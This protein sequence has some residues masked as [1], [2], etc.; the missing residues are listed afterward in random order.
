MSWLLDLAATRE[1]V[2]GGKVSQLAGGRFWPRNS[3]SSAV[4]S[5]VVY[6]SAVGFTAVKLLAV[7]GRY[8]RGGRVSFDCLDFARP[9]ALLLTLVDVGDGKH[10]REEGCGRRRCCAGH[11]G[12]RLRRWRGY[13]AEA[14][15]MRRESA[16]GGA[17][18]QS[19]VHAQVDT[20]GFRGGPWMQDK[21][22]N[23]L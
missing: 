17:M 12:R 18:K 9:G 14:S 3:Y 4:Y 20:A 11:S 23:V 15:E 21:A 1:T 6:S 10:V 19:G 2:G 16:A 8:G 5:S 13:A 7:Y 22:P